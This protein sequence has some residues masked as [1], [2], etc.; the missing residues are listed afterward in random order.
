MKKTTT[1]LLLL[2]FTACGGAPG[3]LKRGMSACGSLTCNAGQYCINDL[4]CSPGCTSDLNCAENQT[5]Q[6][7]GQVPVGSCSNKATMISQADFCNK[8]AACDPMLSMASC[9]QLFDGASETCKQCLMS[10][11][12]STLSRCN[13]ACG[14]HF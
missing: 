7:S 5:C 6:K 11:S 13:N 4:S 14:T 12:C 10:E 2:V 9:K 8:A 1:L 3:E